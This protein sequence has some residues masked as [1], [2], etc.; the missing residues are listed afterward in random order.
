MGA[1]LDLTGNKY[2]YLTV[3]GP[4][5]SKTLACGQRVGMWRCVCDCGKTAV[6]S[7]SKLKSGNNKSCGCMLSAQLRKKKSSDL[8]GMR[9]GTLTIVE[10]VENP[11]GRGAKWLCICD[12]GGARFATTS[13]L[14]QGSVTS[15]GCR[16]YT[17]RRGQ[18]AEINGY[19]PPHDKKWIFLDGNSKNLQADNIV[20]VEPAIYAKLYHRNWLYSD[21][22]DLQK[23]AVMACE[24]E[25][26]IVAAQRQ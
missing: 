23:A 1:R 6:V 2:N 22:P 19:E 25:A 24:L 3:V 5:P 12:C 8:I 16:S 9:F 15:C 26:H 4:A 17:Y 18:F 10:R 11:N 7:T 14:N 21:E 20:F 13:Q